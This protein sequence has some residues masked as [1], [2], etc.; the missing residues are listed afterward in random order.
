MKVNGR[1]QALAALPPAPIGLRSW[2]GPRASLDVVA[3]KKITITA[4]D[5]NRTPVDTNM[6]YLC[7]VLMLFSNVQTALIREEVTLLHSTRST[8][9]Q[10]HQQLT[11]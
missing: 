7:S 8:R 9:N 3:K 11:D 5:E 2:V 4:P 10:S 6:N 1:L